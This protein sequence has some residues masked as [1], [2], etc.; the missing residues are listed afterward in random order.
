M[1]GVY[2]SGFGGLT[3]LRH[4]VGALPGRDFLY[5]GDNGRAPYGGRDAHTLLDFAEQCVEHL[6]E[7]GCGLVVVACHTVSCVALRHLQRRYG[8]PGSGRR[9][10]G[11]TIPA[12]EAAVALTRGRIGVLATER[13]V[14][15]R[16]FVAELAKLGHHDTV[17]RAAPLLAPLVEEAWEATELARGACARY[18]RDL[19]GASVIILGCT[20]YP[21]LRE[22]LEAGTGA[23]LLDPGPAVAERLRAWLSRHP[24]FDA[25]GEGR[26]QL[27]CTGDLAHFTAS[28]A[29]FYGGPLP[30][31]RHVVEAGSTLARLVLDGTPEGQVVRG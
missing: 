10:L 1:I 13:T 29:R 20:H 15:S 27:H 7:A 8:Y 19:E 9:V 11:V 21:L 23:A 18:L 5:L 4:L 3:V 31:P 16:T 12:A 14:R 2:D 28:A 22:A 17:Q 24:D 6:F 30:A 25:P 26:L